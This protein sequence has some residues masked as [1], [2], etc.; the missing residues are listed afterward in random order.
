M[1]ISQVSP[2]RLNASHI[3][4]RTGRNRQ[5][6]PLLRAVCLTEHPVPSQRRRARSTPAF[7]WYNSSV[8]EGAAFFGKH[9]RQTFEHGSRSACASFFKASPGSA[10]LAH[11]F[12]ASRQ[13]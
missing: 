12:R 3:F 5:T 1:R 9:E 10:L 7:F 2:Q 11:A 8:V 4:G 6:S 13:I